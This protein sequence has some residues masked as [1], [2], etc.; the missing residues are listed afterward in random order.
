MEDNFIQDMQEPT[1]ETNGVISGEALYNWD[2]A[3]SWSKFV[4]ISS[5]VLVGI[6]FIIVL[7]LGATMQ[8]YMSILSMT[9]QTG[10]IG[11]IMS[12]FYLFVFMLF[13]GIGVINYFLIKFAIL[14]KRAIRFTDQDAFEKSWYN[15]LWSFRAYGIFILAIILYVAITVVIVGTVDASQFNIPEE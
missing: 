5:L 15:L 4:A 12:F 10:I 9:D 13:G 8:M 2:S 1:P 6:L 7:A 11:A 3:G 14:L